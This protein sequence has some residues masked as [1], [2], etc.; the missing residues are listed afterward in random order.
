MSTSISAKIELEGVS[1][2]KSGIDAATQKTK[3]Y[4]S[5]LTE[6][7]SRSSATGTGAASLSDKIKAQGDIVNAHK[8]KIEEL[9]KKYGTQKENVDKVRAALEEAKKEFGEDSV[10]VKELSAQLDGCEKGLS[11]TQ[12]ELNKTGAALNQAE[13]DAK[14]LDEQVRDMKFDAMQKGLGAVSD[15]LDDAAKKMAPLSLAAAGLLAVSMKVFV[16]FDD[17]MRQ[18]KATMNLT[19]EDGAASFDKLSEAAQKMG[20]ET[21]YTA[22]DAADALNTLAL[23][24]YDT[25]KAISTLPKTLSLAAAGNLDMKYSAELVTDGLNALGLSTDSLDEY[26]DKMARTSQKSATNISQLGEATLAVA[27]QARIAKMP[28]TDMNVA[29]G[30]LANSGIKGSEAGGMLQRVLMNLMDQ[31]GPGAVKMKELGVSAFDAQGNMRPLQDILQDLNAS[32]AD[33]SDKARSATFDE[34]FNVRSVKGASALLNGAG[35]AWNSLAAEIDNAEGTAAQMAAT[36]EEGVGGSLRTMRS[37]LEGAGITFGNTLSPMVEKAAKSVVKITEA[38]QKLSPAQQETIVKTTLAVAAAAPALKM[39]SAAV[40]AIQGVTATI[41]IM[42]TAQTASAAASA[43]S[44]AGLGTMSKAVIALNAAIKANPIGLVIGVAAAATAG[45]IALSVS[46]D[47]AAKAADPLWQETEDLAAKTK[48][49]TEAVAENNAEREKATQCAADNATVAKSLKD[50]I[51]ALSEKEGISAADKELIAQK[52]GKL[53]EMLPDLGLAYDSVT[54]S[55]NLT[56]GE[57]ESYIAN[58]Q[59]Q[60]EADAILQSLTESRK[61]QLDVERELGRAKEDQAAAS[62]QLAEAEKRLGEVIQNR[63]ST[64]GQIYAETQAVARANEEYDKATESVAELTGT[65]DELAKEQ[66]FLNQ[67]LE[68]STAAMAASNEA[69]EGNAGA[70]RSAAEIDAEYIALL[71]ERARIANELEAATAAQSAAQAAEEAAQTALNAAVKTGSASQ[72]ELSA[73][74]AAAHGETV[75]ATEAV[76]GFQAGLGVANETLD[77]TWAQLEA[78]KNAEL[79]LGEAAASTGGQ[80]EAATASA[81]GALGGVA[82]AA[83]EAAGSVAGSMGSAITSIEGAI[84]QAAQSGQNLGKTATASSANEIAAGAPQVTD[85]AKQTVQKAAAGAGV[86]ATDAGRSVGDK[87]VTGGKTAIAAGTPQVTDASK[88]LVQ[89]AAAGAG[90]AATLAGK[91]IGDKIIEGGKTAIEGGAPQIAAA[92]QSSVNAIAGIAGSANTQGYGIGEAL[93]AGAARGVNANAW[94]FADAAAAAA[95]AAYNAAAAQL[96][97]KSPSK[98]FEYLGEMAAEGFSGG[99][100]GGVGDVAKSIAAMSDAAMGAVGVPAS[101]SV[102]GMWGVGQQSGVDINQIADRVAGRIVK[103]LGQ[104]KVVMSSREFDRQVIGAL[105]TV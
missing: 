14:R 81:G 52:V 2:Y 100:L 88:Q 39:A 16:G 8:T 95:L 89:N 5:A 35:E 26:V 98:K 13:A 15:G 87:L 34:V 73:A 48:E 79:A 92:V 56:N 24:G 46:M 80:I 53:N 11:K 21:R 64:F 76:A 40:T 51:V 102:R 65:Q 57:M 97:I 27:G 91:S 105:K 10:Q 103:G 23:A 47:K 77:A 55:L 19:G 22:S 41:H 44:A 38:F 67:K 71:Q 43:A 36:M 101:I 84:P 75:T 45:I 59:R 29:L 54:N 58:I 85:A 49:L 32:M 94:Q 1:Q 20:R 30:L 82:D 60:A 18:V 70:T 42:R 12:T 72:G 74:L 9:T 69:T 28:M 50:E 31:T 33:M 25:D 99:I 90:I 61:Q 66:D 68:D 62:D 3:E 83:G 17:S 104:A 78:A 86:A 6:L 96:K 4:Q 37:A 93:M 63:L 7:A